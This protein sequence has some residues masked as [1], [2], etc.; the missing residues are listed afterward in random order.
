MYKNLQVN[1]SFLKLRTGCCCD[2][3]TVMLKAGM[4]EQEE[5]MPYMNVAYLQKKDIL[6]RGGNRQANNNLLL[7]TFS[8]K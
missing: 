7:C 5:F 3:M 1:N 2:D 4:Y 8:V 6:K